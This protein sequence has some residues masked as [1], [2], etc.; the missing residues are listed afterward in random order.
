MFKKLWLSLLI[1]AA[2]FLT[3][4]ATSAS[5]NAMS[6]GIGDIPVKLNPELKGNV[7]IR[8]VSG[9][10]DTNPLWVSKVDNQGFKA[11]LEQ[12]LIAIGYMA[13]RGSTAKYQVDAILQ[14]LDQPAFGLTFNVKSSVTYT[15]SGQSG[16]KIFPVT[17][18]GSAS[19]SDAFIGME[20]MRIANERSIKENIKL[21]LNNISEQISR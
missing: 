20:R 16:Q 14:D 17:A 19:T 5:Q 11:A 1:L 6:M 18:N 13:P 8:N 21:F 12:S 2:V 10:Q 9:G 7:N 4:C 3:G 15:V